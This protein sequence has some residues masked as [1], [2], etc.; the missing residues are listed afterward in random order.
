ML[1]VREQVHGMPSQASRVVDLLPLMDPESPE[2][3]PDR[4]VSTD[5]E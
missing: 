2:S 3:I 1:Y 5:P 4:N